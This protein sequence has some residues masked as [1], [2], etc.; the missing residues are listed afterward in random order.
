MPSCTPITSSTPCSL[1]VVVVVII[2]IIII[3]THQHRSSPPYTVKLLCFTFVRACARIY[4]FLGYASIHAH[5][6]T[7]TRIYKHCYY[8]RY[9]H[10]HFPSVSLPRAPMYTSIRYK[11]TVLTI[12]RFPTLLLLLVYTVMR[13]R[14][15]L[16]AVKNIQTLKVPC[17]SEVDRFVFC[18]LEA[19][20]EHF[21]RMLFKALL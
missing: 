15:G 9:H 6:H 16:G 7:R 11:P 13:I 20:V 14:L 18:L 12:D 21:T 10:R 8:P 2:I 4:I 17:Y 5:T 1:V 19:T 3:I